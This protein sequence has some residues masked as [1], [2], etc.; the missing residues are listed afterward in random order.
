[1]NKLQQIR[2]RGDWTLL[3]IVIIGLAV[4]MGFTP[5]FEKIQGG[6]A[7]AVVGSSFGAIFVIVLTMYLLNKQTEIEQESKKSERVFDEKVQLYQNILNTTRDMIEDGSISI[8]E[9]T[10][11]P[12]AMINLQMLGDD[13]VIENYKAVF[14]RL[15]D[16]F[17]GS[18]LDSVVITPEQKMGIYNDM[19]KFASKC[20]V[21]LGVSEKEVG[22]D[23]FKETTAALQKS[24]DAIEGRNKP[25]AKKDKVDQARAS[26][27]GSDYTIVRYKDSSIRIIKDGEDNPVNNTRAIMREINEEYDLG[28]IGHTWNGQKVNT[29]SQGKRMIDLLNRRKEN[30]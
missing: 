20:R 15:N 25:L 18:E 24:S 6:V 14:E 21:D 1:M 11:L 13:K 8:D 4:Y 22:D 17:A 30:E 23:L 19:S 7:G 5:L 10:K 28:F 16:I 2:N 9:I 3:A 29:R 12:F 27:G 26:C